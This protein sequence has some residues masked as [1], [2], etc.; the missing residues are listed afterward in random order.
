MLKL[1]GVSKKQ[2]Y[3]CVREQMHL[4]VTT[5]RLHL[6]QKNI[7][8]QPTGCP[9]LFLYCFVTYRGGYSIY[10][11]HTQHYRPLLLQ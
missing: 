5:I 8:G 9:S 4:M 2:Y 7:E 1:I 10:I 6:Y 11:T 3:L